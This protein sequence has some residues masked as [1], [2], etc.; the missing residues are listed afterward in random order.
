MDHAQPLHLATGSDYEHS[1]KSIS[2]GHIDNA[3]IDDTEH[4]EK[5]YITEE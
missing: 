4:F 5:G 1:I 3:G 2:A